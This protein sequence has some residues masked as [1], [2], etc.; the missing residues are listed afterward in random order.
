M[1]RTLIP[2]FILLTSM[3]FAATTTQEPREKNGRFATTG[4]SDSH[5]VIRTQA[6]HDGMSKLYDKAGSSFMG[7]NSEEHSFTVDANGNPSEITTSKRER[8][9][10]VTVTKGDQAIVHTHPKSGKPEPSEG[11]IAVAKRT[12]IPNYSLSKNEL[13]VANPDG[14]TAHVADV[15]WKHGQLDIKWKD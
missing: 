5:S 9:N 2:L 12:G 14:S 13:W 7:Q 4:G 3:A 8:G 10:T 6:V 15:Q 1:K 11:D